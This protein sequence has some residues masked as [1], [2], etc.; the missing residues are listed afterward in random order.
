MSDR[1]NSSAD[2]AGTPPW[3]DPA[4]RWLLLAPTGTVGVRVEDRHTAIRRLRGLPAG[5]PVAIVGSRT[6]RTIARQS[7]V[8]AGQ[9][10]LVLP[11]LDLPVAVAAPGP[12]LKWV[13]NSVLTVPSGRY[14][15]HLVA[16]W[17]VHLARRAPWLL[18]AV[19]GRVLLGSRR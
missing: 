8:D 12:G 6:I 5:S 4:A 17:A 10:F 2:T 1:L 15:G 19:G 9:T 3:S 16:T 13:A 11:G 7:E 14:R 18:R